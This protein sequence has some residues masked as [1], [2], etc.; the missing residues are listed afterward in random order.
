MERIECIVSG[1]VQGVFFRANTVN[2]SKNFQVTGFV[3][4]LPLGNVEIIAEGE[5]K[6]LEKFLKIIKNFSFTRIDKIEIKWKK[7]ENEFSEF[8]IKY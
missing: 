2:A 3:R 4:N 7:A 8:Q 5:K 1:R 6:E